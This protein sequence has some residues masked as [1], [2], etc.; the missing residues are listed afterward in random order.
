[1]NKNGGFAHNKLPEGPP[2]GGLELCGADKLGIDKF[3]ESVGGQGHFRHIAERNETSYL[4]STASPNI[5][6]IF[7]P[8]L[9]EGQRPP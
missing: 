5:L 1:M 8:G 2:S 6:E 9:L 3:E 7:T 4:E